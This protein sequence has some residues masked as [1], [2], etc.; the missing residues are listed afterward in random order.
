[1]IASGLGLAYLI[2]IG[3]PDSLCVTDLPGFLG[4]LT[5]HATFRASYIN[6]DRTEYLVYA[7]SGQVWR[8]DQIEDISSA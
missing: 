8:L 4:V 1:M 2:R 6:Y 7:H 3:F 5:L